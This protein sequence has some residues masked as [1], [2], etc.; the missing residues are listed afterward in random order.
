MA[1]FYV[2]NFD[3]KITTQSKNFYNY[4][5]PVEALETGPKFFGIGIIADQY[6]RRLNFDTRFGESGVYYQTKD[7]ALAS[8]AIAAISTGK[9][10]A[11]LLSL[12]KNNGGRTMNSLAGL[13]SVP[14]GNKK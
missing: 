5:S 4:P 3:A 13:E 7:E 2:T 14:F 10:F 6:G 9:S 8:Y 12:D 11:E 1:E